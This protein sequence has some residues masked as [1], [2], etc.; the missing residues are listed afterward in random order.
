[1]EASFWSTSR[2][3][4]GPLN[5][6]LDLKMPVTETKVDVVCR[7]YPAYSP[8][9]HLS[10]SEQELQDGGVVVE[11]LPRLQEAVKLALRLGVERVVEVPLLFIE[12]ALD[13]RHVRRREH[14]D[15]PDAM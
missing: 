9:P 14:Q 13:D 12:L 7:T 3:S 10:Q 8:E 15:R 2:A 4:K 1:M 11:H 5:V 6:R